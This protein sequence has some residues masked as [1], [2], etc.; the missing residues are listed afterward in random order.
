M[1]TY[2]PPALNGLAFDAFTYVEVTFTDANTDTPIWHSLN[3]ARPEDVI[4][5]PV[6]R[7]VDCNVYDARIA[8]TGEVSS[9]WTPEKI[10]LRSNAPAKVTL[11]LATKRSNA[12]TPS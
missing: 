3:P 8:N 12:P 10:V 11:L 1:S 7:S 2:S 4:Y 9:V 6:A 5:I